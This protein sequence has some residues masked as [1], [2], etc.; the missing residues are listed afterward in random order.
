MEDGDRTRAGRLPLIA[1]AALVLGALSLTLG[2]FKQLSSIIGPTFLAVNL[3]ITAYPLYRW[4]ERRRVPRV[5]SALCTGLV[6]FL[7]LVI[8]MGALVWSGA[9]MVASLTDYGPQFTVLYRQGIDL[10]A[11]LGFAESFLQ[12]QLK[13]ISPS[14]VITLVGN[15]VNEISG[16]TGA[17][18]V[19]LICM[20]FMVFDL[21]TMA[22]RLQITDRLH[23]H[24]TQSLE[25]FATGI[26]RYWLVTTVFGLIVALLDGVVLVLV[27]V[28]LPLVWVI[29]SFITNYIP[30]IG[31]VLGLLPPALLTL[32]EKGPWEALVVVVAYSALNFVIQSIIQPKFTG[33]AVGVTPVVS[34]LSLLLWTAVFGP[35]GALLALPLTLMVKSLLLDNDPKVRW[36]GAFIAADPSVVDTGDC[37]DSPAGQAR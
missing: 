1:T 22:R 30:N 2:L 31:F 16:A 18:F 34:F 14:N 9:S 20:F 19:I 17:L 3:L 37:E 5:L 8:G 6:L 12:E 32:F 24:F 33:D 23:P 27:G 25:A 26:R 29:L 10:L 28:P 4:L 13:S 35:L 15:V 36:M 21:P 11:N 7:T